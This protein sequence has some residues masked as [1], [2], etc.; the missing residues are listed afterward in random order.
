MGKQ[1]LLFF[2][3]NDDSTVDS[4]GTKLIRLYMNRFV[5][6]EDT[7]MEVHGVY[8]VAESDL[9]II[10]KDEKETDN[11]SFEN[12]IYD[13][14]IIDNILKSVEN[15]FIS[16]GSSCETHCIIGTLFPQSYYMREKYTHKIKKLILNWFRNNPKSELLN[17]FL[18]TLL[19]GEDYYSE[20]FHIEDISEYGSDYL[21]IS[22]HLESNT[23]HGKRI[24][25]YSGDRAK[26]V[27]ED[28]EKFLQQIV[29]SIAPLHI[30]PEATETMEVKWLTSCSPSQISM[31]KI[32]YRDI[33][34]TI[35]WNRWTLSMDIDYFA[36]N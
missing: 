4:E 9:Q 10:H 6:E 33:Y 15:N 12:E 24:Q 27:A 13:N 8:H 22:Q 7:Q 18:L 21:I 29:S 36:N 34:L 14:R 23:F 32:L 2:V 25:I 1:N 3:A 19:M 17:S 16:K 28:L 5:V 26:T 11:Q 30:W 31:K 35:V 20:E